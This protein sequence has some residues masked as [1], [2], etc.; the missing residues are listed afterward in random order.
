MPTSASAAKTIEELRD[1]S[2]EDLAAQHDGLAKSTFVGIGYYRDE[3]SR[4]VFERQGREMLRLTIVIATLTLV[5][6]G[7]VIV[8][9]ST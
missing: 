4:R 3:L 8:G 9:L 1:L 5:N 6:V 7:V 2:D